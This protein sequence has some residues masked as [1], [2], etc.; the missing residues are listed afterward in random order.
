MIVIMMMMMIIT[1]IIINRVNVGES[2]VSIFAVFTSKITQKK[3][4]KPQH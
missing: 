2:S 1:K 4:K 3:G